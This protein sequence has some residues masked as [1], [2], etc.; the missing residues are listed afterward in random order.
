M[1]LFEAR[2]IGLILAAAVLGYLI[3]AKSDKQ[4]IH[5]L[6]GK[7]FREGKETVGAAAVY[8][9]HAR[10]RSVAQI[11]TGMSVI[12]AAIVM[13]QAGYSHP[14]VLSVGS[15]GAVLC[16]IGIVGRV[17]SFMAAIKDMSR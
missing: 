10:W 13:M 7:L 12:A 9:S 17:R 2:A 15:V 14:A 16:L 5:I 8:R 11:T 1:W 4:S 6:E 3:I